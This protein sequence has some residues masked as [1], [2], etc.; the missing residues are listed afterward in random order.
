MIFFCVLPLEWSVFSQL[1]F[2]LGPVNLLSL[3]VTYIALTRT[4]PESVLWGL[5]LGAISALCY[6]FGFGAVV[7]AYAWSALLSRLVAYA[8]PFD[9]RIPFAALA[10]FQSLLSKIIWRILTYKNFHGIPLWDFILK[11]LPTLLTTLILAY[12]MLPLMVFWDD[13]FENNA[14]TTASDLNPRITGMHH[15]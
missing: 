7:S 4:L 2:Y 9:S 14:S 12:L 6:P 13:F 3:L 10:C 11:N 15:R 5:S 8:L 1:P